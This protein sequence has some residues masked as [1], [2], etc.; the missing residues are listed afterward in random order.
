MLTRERKHRTLCVEY[1]EK[2]TKTK[3]V[4]QHTTNGWSPIIVAD[5][6]VV[7][8]VHSNLETL[9]PLMVT[10]SSLSCLFNEIYVDVAVWGKVS[11]V[12]DL[13]ARF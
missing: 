10:E 5:V 7:G 11:R 12:I 6:V 1:G 8:V 3:R 4:K 9:P 2:E 13:L